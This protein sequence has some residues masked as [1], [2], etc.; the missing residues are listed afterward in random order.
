MINL[1]VLL[2]IGSGA[3]AYTPEEVTKI[4]L[5][6]FPLIE[7]ADRKAAAQEALVTSAKGGFDHKLKAKTRNRIDGDYENDFYQVEVQRQTGLGGLGLNAG[8]RQGIGLFPAYDGKLKTSTGGEIFAGLTLPL[9]RGF[10]TDRNRTD[11]EV[12]KLEE[13][14]AKEELRLKKN[15]YVHKAL[16]LYYKWLLG[17]KILGVQESILKLAETRES[18]VG[19]RHRRGD[20][21]KIKEVDAKR[22]VLKRRSEILKTQAKQRLLEAE[23]RLFIP[24]LPEA[25]VLPEKPWERKFKGKLQLAEL[26]QLRIL[27]LE[28]KKITSRR[29]LAENEKMPELSVALLGSRELTAD[30]PYG[31]E[32]IQVGVGFTFPL[33]NRKARGKTVAE[34]YKKKALEKRLEFSSREY[35]LS[36]ESLRE[37][38]GVLLESWTNLRSESEATDTMARGERAKWQQGGSD[39]YFVN[40]REEDV[41]EVEIKK[42]S[43]IVELAQT[44]I[45]LRLLEVALVP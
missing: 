14:Q 4:V 18:M 15:M 35:A 1:L 36:Y 23:L 43:T 38:Y 37:S 25:D 11:L 32:A 26:P 24:E 34:E 20:V 17:R 6:R 33:E 41:A 27:E 30:G 8:I 22:S 3:L 19:R 21:E 29:R 45:D 16:S 7:E 5:E 39:L 2:L 44:D 13:A 9:L 10:N 40:L 42:W 31:R 28:K 12:A